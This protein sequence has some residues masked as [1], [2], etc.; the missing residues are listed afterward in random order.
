MKELNYYF[1]RDKRRK[2]YK[3]MHVMN[4]GKRTTKVYLQKLDKQN[5]SYLKI[6][7]LNLSIKIQ[8]S[9]SLEM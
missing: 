1:Q 9:N 5:R 2:G 4:Y 8:T 7:T 6:D 3:L